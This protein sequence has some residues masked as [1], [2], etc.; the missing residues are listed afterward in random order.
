M[1]KI[2]L[3]MLSLMLAPAGLWAN[4]DYQ[5]ADSLYRE[6]QYSEALYYYQQLA[7]TDR[8]FRQNFS[9]NFKIAVCYLKEGAFQKSGAIFQTLR[10]QKNELPEYLDYFY[11]CSLLGQN[12]IS[13]ARDAGYP[14]LEKYKRHYLA[15]SLRLHLADY[16]YKIKNYHAAEM[17]Y[18]LLA[19]NKK[20]KDLRSYLET[21]I[22]YCKMY[23][24]AEKEAVDR[25][26]QII[27]KYPASD[28]ALRV[29]GY[30]NSDENLRQKYFFSIADV[31]L[32]HKYYSELTANLE[33]YIKSTDDKDEKERARFYLLKVYFAR[34]DYQKALY[35]F[36]TMLKSL[37]D[38][39]LDSH[40]RLMIAR[41]RLRLDD[42]SGAADAYI[43][44]SEKYPR[45]RVAVDASWKAAWLYEELGDIKSALAQYQ[46]ITDHWSSS[47]Y[48]R[49][50]KF[51]VGLSFY[52]LRRYP[53]AETVFRSI[54]N[55]RW[56]DFHK[57]RA[58]YWLAKVFRKTG[59]DAEAES[60]FVT[61]SQNLF[62]SYY[63]IKSFLQINSS[64]NQI[65]DSHTNLVNYD[66]PLKQYTQSIGS[67]MDE[68]ARIFRVQEL[69]GDAYAHQE[70]EEK[71]YQASTMGEWIALAE[72]YKRLQ[73]YHRAFQV[74][75]YINNRYFPD[76]PN[77]EK[78]YLLKEAY[79][80]YY[81][82][83]IGTYCQLRLLDKNMVLAI[84]RAESAYDRHAHSWA[85]AYGLMQLIPPTASAIA[86]ELDF[87][88]S[89]NQMLFDAD[90][91]INL[92]TFYFK[93]LLDQFDNRIEYALAA[94]NA[95]PHRVSSWQN[96]TPDDELDLFVENI[97]FAQTRNYVRKVMRNYWIYKFLDKIN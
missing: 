14:F 57:E 40:L 16:E 53:Q 71:N 20:Y 33:E 61:L 77:E 1:N 92:G 82:N 42:K 10:Q 69:L 39:T 94:Y 34:S 43:E 89:S 38:Q 60:L 70:L 36:N 29:A 80:L 97:E 9:V 11:F 19:R 78:P 91:N 26:Y 28:E 6:G 3:L 85:D 65:V 32:E 5:I 86:S 22:A 54:I 73:A 18:S 35:G 81:D 68:F 59:R 93:K 15:D 17:H 37:E 25:M 79:P 96:I 50:A 12:N 8:Y 87:D 74:Y 58:T 27:E 48:Q 52:R 30:I 66:N 4:N 23:M 84:I 24:G 13:S 88:L 55:S 72:V 64:I 41:T 44:Y 46:K 31:Y 51:R 47:G 21:Q 75:D 95:G 83:I 49:E 63:A 62:E 7:N 2:R 45:R 76:L 56:D 67:V 90:V